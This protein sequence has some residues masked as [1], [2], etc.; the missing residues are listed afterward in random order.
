MHISMVAFPVSL[1]VQRAI[2]SDDAIFHDIE[3]KV[4]KACD[5]EAHIVIRMFEKTTRTWNHDVEFEYEIENNSNVM[6]VSVY[7]N[8][9]IY[10]FIDQGTSVRYA[11]MT[12]DYFSKSTPGVIG[13]NR[14]AGELLYIDK[15]VPRP[16]IESR[17]FTEEIHK[18][19]RPFFYKKIEKVVDKI[20]KK[21]YDD[22]WGR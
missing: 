8:D 5:D 19:R 14:G 3:N 6:R 1:R 7:T 4:E 9:E 22:M 15:N 17:R 20:V 18:R 12:K 21:Y 2:V 13:S 11:T 10:Y 16:G